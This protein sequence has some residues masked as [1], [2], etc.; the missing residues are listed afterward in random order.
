M[1]VIEKIVENKMKI[2][3]KNKNKKS[4]EEIKKEAYDFVS[5]KTEK[6]RF[7]EKLKRAKQ[8]LN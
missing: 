5:T 7:E 1:N 3:M 2:L 8:K 4:L 6:F